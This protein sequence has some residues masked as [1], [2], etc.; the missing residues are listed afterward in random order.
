MAPA[1]TGRLA[2]AEEVHVLLAHLD[3]AGDRHAETRLRD[4]I[5][6][7]VKLTRLIPRIRLAG[8]LS[9]ARPDPRGLGDPVAEAALSMAGAAAEAAERTR[10]ERLDIVATAGPRLLV[11]A[12]VLLAGLASSLSDRINGYIALEDAPSR[13][14]PIPSMPTRRIQGER[15][16]QIAR[17]AVEKGSI[18]YEE[19]ATVLR[20]DESTVRRLA[21]ELA[22][23][24]LLECTRRQRRMECRPTGTLLLLHAAETLAEAVNSAGGHAREVGNR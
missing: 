10:P 6:E 12:A 3:P 13:E 7:V 19:A 22:R 4:A 14:Y 1:V 8:V 11:A 23:E 15:K 16:A 17:L 20:V 21:Q 9:V 5:D 24:G 2:T 18:G